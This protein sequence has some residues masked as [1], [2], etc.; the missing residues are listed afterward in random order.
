GQVALACLLLSAAGL[1]LSS[2]NKLRQVD[3]GFNSHHLTTALV[4]YSGREFKANPV[5]QASFVS[6]VVDQ[7]SAQPGVV[8]AAAVEPPPFDPDRVEFSSFTVQ[9]QPAKLGG[10]GYQSGECYATPGYLRVAGIPLLAGRWFTDEDRTDAA[11]VVVID[12]TLKRKY[13]PNQDPVGQR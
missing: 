5:K 4:V 3:L 9:S 1:F 8:A 12:E 11:P 10:A 6:G 2:L 13:W 7:L